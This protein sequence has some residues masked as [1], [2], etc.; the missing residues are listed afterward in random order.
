MIMENIWSGVRGEKKI[1]IREHIQGI[2]SPQVRRHIDL[3]HHVY[4]LLRGYVSGAIKHACTMTVVFV[5]RQI[6]V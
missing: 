1:A 5:F 6:G 3:K 4:A 2:L